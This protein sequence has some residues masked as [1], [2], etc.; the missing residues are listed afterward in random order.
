[1][2]EL[3]AAVPPGRQDCLELLR[4]SPRALHR[5]GG[6]RHL[7]AS[8]VV[9][10]APAEHVALMWHRKGQFWVQP[11]GHLEEGEASSEKA[12]RREVTE[13]TGL[14][15]RERAGAGPAGLHGPTLE[16]ALG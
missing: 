6:P 5:E 13:E 16:A 11:G 15:A 4:S 10:D 1:M 8:A 2:A 3:C 14:E 12:A 9:I 7:T